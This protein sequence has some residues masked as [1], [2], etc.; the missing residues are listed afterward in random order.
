MLMRRAAVAS[1]LLWMRGALMAEPGILVV[2]ITSTLQ[3]RR[4]GWKTGGMAR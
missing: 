3:R 4:G 1:A 2:A